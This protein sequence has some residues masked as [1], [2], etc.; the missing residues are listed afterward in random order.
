[1][2]KKIFHLSANGYMGGAERAILNFSNGQKQANNYLV[3][4]IFF[5]TGAAVEEAKKFGIETYL[6]KQKFQLSNIIT[7]YKAVKELRKIFKEETPDILVFHMSYSF[8]VGYFASLFLDVK[9][10]WF[11]HGPVDGTLDRIASLL[12]IHHTLFNT[13]YL[14]NAHNSFQIFKNTKNQSITPLGV[15]YSFTDEQEVQ[16]IRR[17]YLTGTKNSLIIMAGRITES[18]G[19][20][21]LLE[22]I[23][24]MHT[25]IY[26][27][28]LIIGN[29]NSEIDKLYEQDL[30]KL[31]TAKK[32]GSNISFI[33]YKKNIADYF[34]ASD[35]LVL[36]TIIPESFG[37]VAAEAM[38]A[39]SL[40]IGTNFGGITE[41]LKDR[42][43]GLVFNPRANEA[44][45]VLENLL[46]E[47]IQNPIQ[48][49]ELKENAMK[50]IKNKYSITSTTKILEE[51][52]DKL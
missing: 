51:A 42:E 27:H 17:N 45:D 43:T 26:A 35:V 44:S 15:P 29:A 3:K 32:I 1:M 12:P 52:L 18:K 21:L 33:G 8:I 48:F 10:V 49:K 38:Q 14:Q 46:T 6:L 22:A 34:K 7:L 4:I 28:F 39:D 40:V 25:P 11:Q 23:Q 37:L 5:N 30:I 9:R 20:H 2:N 13:K 31:C 16:D 36:A 19:H 24:K 50:I 47:A 41:I